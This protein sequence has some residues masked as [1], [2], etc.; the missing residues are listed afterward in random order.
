MNPYAATVLVAG[1]VLAAPAPKEKGDAKK[2]QG[3]W[4]GVSVRKCGE[5]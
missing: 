2:F 5:E 3:A 4:K 1:L